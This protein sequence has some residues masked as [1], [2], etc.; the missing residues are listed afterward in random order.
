MKS[1]R[2]YQQRILE[3]NIVSG[4]V[5][6]AVAAVPLVFLPD[7]L[8]RFILPKLVV[9]FLAVAFAFAVQPM[10]RIHPKIGWLLAA[11]PF[12]YVVAAAVSSNPWAA[13]VGRW[14]RYEG[15][16]VLLLYVALF[17]LGGRLFGAA[18]GRP[19]RRFLV[20]ALSISAV[21][22]API[23]L[24]EALGFRPL[25]GGEDMRPG[26][27]MGNATDLGLVG[28]VGCLTLLPAALQSKS[29]LLRCGALAAAVTVVA[30]GSR[31]C[32]S[33]LVAGGVVLLGV[34]A[35]SRFRRGRRA[36]ALILLLAFTAGAVALIWSIPSVANRIFST[37]TVVGRVFLWEASVSSL[38]E[39]F[40]FGLGGGRFVDV[41]PVHLSENFA[42]NV[43]TDFPADSPHML[44]LQLVSAGG[45]IF[46]VLVSILVWRVLQRG[47]KAARAKGDAEYRLFMI[48]G[49]TACCAYG[50]ALLT[51]FTSPGTMALVCLLAGAIAA[52]PARPELQGVPNR[53]KA[54][55]AA[56]RIVI[57]ALALLA[58]CGAG[59][60][61]VAELWMKTA[62]TFAASGHIEQASRAFEHARALRPWD[63]DL[64][65]LAGQAFASRAVEDDR[66]AAVAALRWGT[67]ALQRNPE[68]FEAATVLA[69]GQLGTGD[70]QTATATLDQLIARSPQTAEPHLLRGL[71]RASSSD[72][73]GAVTDL[74]R[75][76]ALTPK[77][78][79]A[80]A[81]LAQLRRETDSR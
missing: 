37:E 10:T 47:V 27:T 38:S 51:H 41:L 18:S 11:I 22:L 58:A 45:I 40:L 16:P 71:A 60:G 5:A 31:A 59:V 3:K 66:A 76:A 57:P 55:A 50:A 19:A 1:L 15:L 81:I 77:P 75:A 34:R 44:P 30:S 56:A 17:V 4:V 48:G 42:K 9:L 33:V 63:Q 79:R 13:L 29:L 78:Q 62:A 28:L 20:M 49:V 7:G 8:Y 2:Q 24:A 69:I 21:C 14:P 43:G 32:I 6:V 23:A 72:L 61:A 74:K 26:S 54:T 25:G 52:P 67:F 39:S 53:R 35:F 65:L 64:D 12:S 68:S 36:S 80:E 46:L 70:V 73:P